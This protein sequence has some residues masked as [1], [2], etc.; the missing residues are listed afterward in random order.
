MKNQ[1]P[2]AGLRD[3]DSRYDADACM[4]RSQCG[5]PGYH[6]RLPQGL[7]VHAVREALDYA[8]ALLQTGE[9]AAAGRAAGIIG[10]VLTLQDA[11]PFSGT[12]GIWPWFLEEPLDKMDPPDW[13]WADFCGATLA[14]MLR[15]HAAL[16]PAG[17]VAAM[18]DAL[19]HAA[20]CI[21]RRNVRLDYTNIAIMGGGVAAAAG[22]LLDEPRLTAFGR[23]RLERIMDLVRCHGGFTE[24][25]SPT[26]TMVALHESERIL[27]L[28]REPGVRAA[29][30][31]LRQTAWEVIA[32]HFHPPTQQWAGPHA[33]AYTDHIQPALTHYLARQTG[34]VIL[35]HG[36][37][38][39]ARPA[40]QLVPPLP[41]PEPWRARF[42]ALPQ[43]PWEIRRRFVRREDPAVPPPER[44][45]SDTLVERGRRPL[46]AH[47]YGDRTGTTWFSDTATLGSCNHED[48]WAQRRFL[49]GYIRTAADSAVCLRLRFLHDGRDFA[50]GFVRQAQSGPRVLSA[51]TLIT[52]RGDWHPFFDHPADGVFHAE[53][54]RLR[55][56]LAGAGVRASQPAADRFELIAGEHRVVVQA[57]PGRFGAHTVRWECGQEEGRAFVDAVCYHGPRAAF[58]FHDLGPVQ[59]VGGL[60]LVEPGREPAPDTV[61]IRA[62]AGP[63]AFTAAWGALRV[64]VPAPADV[65]PD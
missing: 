30:E 24:Y 2:D 43:A 37:A 26:Y 23:M 63:E 41:C 11:N 53:D 65:Y 15:D 25:N 46:P 5:T 44:F 28:C 55:Y 51:L 49:L 42:T 10:K 14:Q 62:G 12:Y 22:E 36:P 34:A 54:F 13:N 57:P 20:W 58:P 17:L 27:H 45:S 39:G 18:R 50:S 40:L 60:E 33:R 16:L 1:Q 47:R 64:D 52:N 29:A 32:D 7:E 59:V 21:F 9:A 19:G 6:S 3:L 8:L 35:P 48:T 56:E 4:P 38:D 61:E 31:A